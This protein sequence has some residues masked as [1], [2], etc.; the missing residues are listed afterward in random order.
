MVYLCLQGARV[1]IGDL[2]VSDGEKVAR[3]IGDN[4]TFVP[5]DVSTSETCNIISHNRT[6]MSRLINTIAVLVL[7]CKLRQI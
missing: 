3:E 2:Q 5:M 4:A 1:I 7:S 6:V